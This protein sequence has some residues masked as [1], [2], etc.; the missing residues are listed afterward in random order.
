MEF[1]G[2]QFIPGITKKRLVEEHQARY[3][4]AA[5]FV[6]GQ[7]VLDIACGTGYG[8]NLLAE[9]ANRVIGADVSLESI[10]YATDHY[11]RS[12][13]QYIKAS[14]E[15]DIFSENAFDIVCSFETIEHL[16]DV[17]REK[18]FVNI[19]KWLKPNGQLFISTPNKKIT[20]PFT[21]KPLNEFHVLEYDL[22][23]LIRE[24]A[25]YFKI[26]KIMG[27]RI[28][29]NFFT[30]KI[31]RRFFNLAQRFFKF[32]SDIYNIANGA[33]ILEFDDKKQEPRIF[34][35]VCKNI[36]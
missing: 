7:A 20:S 27:Q 30:Q 2:E 18:F 19:K 21:V 15:E 23:T 1:T 17:T 25:N 33:E 31:I 8:T 6:K 34:F 11:Q 26:E 10:N 4:Y 24:I 36:K 3:N 16:D 14:V 12:N 29:N 35:L 28:V 22:E 9:K 32:G 5:D 13:L